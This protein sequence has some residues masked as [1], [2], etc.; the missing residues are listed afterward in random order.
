MRRPARVRSVLISVL[1]L[2]ELGGCP[3]ACKTVC[4]APSWWLGS[5]QSKP[6][7]TRFSMSV[8]SYFYGSQLACLL[9]WW[10][11]VRVV[12]RKHLYDLCAGSVL[13]RPL[14]LSERTILRLHERRR[15]AFVALPCALALASLK[16]SL[17]A[18][19]VVALSMSLYHLTESSA[20]NRHGEYPLLYNAWAMV[21]PGRLA[22]AASFGIAVH[23]VLSSGIAKLWY[24]GLEWCSPRTMAVYLDTYRPSKS[25]PPLSRGLSAWLARR[26]WAT[27][28]IAVGTVALE[29]VLVPATLLLPSAASRR[30]GTALMV[31]M[32]LGIGGAMS[33]RVGIVFL[34]TLPCYAVGFS[35]DAPV[36]SREWW[37]AAALAL[38]PT[39]LAVARRR[40]LPE[41]WPISPISLFMWNGAQAERLAALLMTGDTRL[42][43]GCATA[44]GAGADAETDA[45]PLLG[46]RVVHHGERP[47][48][49]QGGGKGTGEEAGEE[50]V[51]HDAVL[52]VVGFT[53]VHAE[54]GALLAAADVRTYTRRVE[55]WLRSERRLV[56]V[57][58]G[59][60]LERAYVVRLDASGCVVEV[61]ARG[62]QPDKKDK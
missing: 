32:H 21:L 47:R 62:H 20:T 29:C 8:Q 54:C 55:E 28:A 56:E 13:T 61:L 60:T 1:V 57:S 36:G 7:T 42:V 53:L 58:S 45:T 12:T 16:P 49:G 43:L 22:H 19:L 31:A 37:L 50:V 2:L 3:P 27:R 26:A 24:G 23:F 30:V 11:V 33:A 48:G 4:I 38:L 14:W 18:R 15:T 41:A 5:K 44:T 51:V 40:P 25:S 6:N 17:V 34:T 59:R 10:C 9:A 39:A 35:C 46:R 52:R